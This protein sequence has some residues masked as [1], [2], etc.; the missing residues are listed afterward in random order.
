MSNRDCMMALQRHLWPRLFPLFALLVTLQL[1]IAKESNT[2]GSSLHLEVHSHGALQAANAPSFLHQQAAA[3]DGT[4]QQT[5][6][7]QEH[8]RGKVLP[9]D[10]PLYATVNWPHGRFSL[11]SVQNENV[12]LEVEDN[13]NDVTCSTDGC[14]S[15]G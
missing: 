2:R 3:V 10:D 13:C 15:S 8:R 12:C 7:R 1:C 11:Q 5:V 9:L 6:R 4:G 14:T